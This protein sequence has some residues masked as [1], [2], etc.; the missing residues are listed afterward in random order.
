[1]CSIIGIAV[2][3]YLTIGAAI[4]GFHYSRTPPEMRF[5]QAFGGMGA[6]GAV[7]AGYR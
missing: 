3:A 7:L 2:C 4:A 6:G 5:R 1:M